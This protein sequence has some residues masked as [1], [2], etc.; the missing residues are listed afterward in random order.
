MLKRYRKLVTVSLILAAFALLVIIRI[1]SPGK[2]AAPKGGAEGRRNAPVSVETMVIGTERISDQIVSTGTILADEEVEL[3]SEISGKITKILFNEGAP[4]RKGQLLVKINDEDLQA[5]L[6]KA[7]YK[8]KLLQD[9]EYRQRMMLKKEGISQQEYDTALNEL[10]M[11]DAEIQLIKV[12]IDKTELRAPFDGVVGLKSVSV[13]SYL[14]PATKIATL[15]KLNPVKLEFSIP[16]KYSSIVSTGRKVSFTL[17]NSAEKYNATVYAIEPKISEATR[18]LIIRARSGN[19]G[20]KIRPGAF[21]EIGLTLN[22]VNNAIVVPSQTIVPDFKGQ[23]V[24][25]YS[26]GKAK[27]VQVTTGIRQEKNVQITGGLKAGDTLITSGI[28]QL[29][30]N[31]RVKLKGDEGQGGKPRNNSQERKASI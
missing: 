7:Q 25:L 9:R 2:A 5:Q 29:K 6:L 27:P 26:G 15:Q 24:F 10:N 22:E 28:M 14:S 13:G 23:K 20:N 3:R 4:V 16:E 8:K 17:Q 21:A 18:T 1:S 12:Q 30:P 19:Q 31:M 11:Q